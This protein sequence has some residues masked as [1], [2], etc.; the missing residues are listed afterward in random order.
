MKILLPLVALAALFSNFSSAAPEPKDL[1]LKSLA[2]YEARW[3]AQKPRSYS[4]TL[5]R[6]CFCAPRLLSAR[7]QVTGG[8]SKMV[9][10]NAAVA[11]EQFQAYV[12]VDKLFKAAR[13][14]L[15]S[16]GRVAVTYDAKRVQ[17][18]QIILDRNVQATDDELYLTVSKFSR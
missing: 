1:T 5:E 9:S 4:F 18:V 17:P 2:Q 7:F 12:S 14:I 13:E 11:R 8:V 15:Q 3:N 16:G 10:S 6:T